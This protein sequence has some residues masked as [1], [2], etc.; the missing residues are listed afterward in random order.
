M[1]FP[2]DPAPVHSC[3][4]RVGEPCGEPITAEAAEALEKAMMEIGAIAL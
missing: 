2:L 4:T 3:Q 1:T